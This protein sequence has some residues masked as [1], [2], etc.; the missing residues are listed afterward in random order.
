MDFT[1]NLPD[2]Y[3]NWTP[4]YGTINDQIINVNPDLYKYSAQE[5][6]VGYV[7][8]TGLSPVRQTGTFLVN[9][10]NPYQMIKVGSSDVRNYQGDDNPWSFSSASQIFD[11]IAAFTGQQYSSLADWRVANSLDPWTGKDMTDYAKELTKYTNDYWSQYPTKE[12]SGLAKGFSIAVPA[13]IAAMGGYGALAAPVAGAGAAAAEAGAVGT[14]GLGVSGTIGSELAVSG[15]LAGAETAGMVGAGAS[16]GLLSGMTPYT[17]GA[18]LL[19]TGAAL[20][21]GG[22]DDMVYQAPADSGLT[23]VDIAGQY[24]GSE[25]EFLSALQKMPLG[26]LAKAGLTSYDVQQ[27]LGNST[28]NGNLLNN[29]LKGGSSLLSGASDYA[30]P[31]SLLANLAGKIWGA[32]EQRSSANTAVDNALNTAYANAT[33]A[34]ENNREWWSENAYP[35]KDLMAAKRAQSYSDLATRMNSAE[36]RMR[37]NA[38][39]SGLRGGSLSGAISNLETAAQKD[40]GKLATEL[41]EFENTPLFAPSGTAIGT[42]IN[43]L[44]SPLQMTGVGG[45]VSDYVDDLTKTLSTYTM[46]NNMMKNY[47]NSGTNSNYLLEALFK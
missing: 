28:S 43:P 17:T 3:K 26:E 15:G 14:G 24:S 22:G 37:E 31:L 21:G 40:Y 35:N 38:A 29:I 42:N 12:H 45:S 23:S 41:M 5:N 18:S 11:P 8:D 9:P 4:W 39:K 33:K 1:K 10:S 46:Y 36:E 20:S 32:D 6:H 13:L 16:G 25:P 30:L 19:S 27:I 7:G 47:Q 34:A 2:Q 44:L